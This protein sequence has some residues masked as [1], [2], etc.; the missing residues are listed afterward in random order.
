MQSSSKNRRPM[1]TGNGDNGLIA[2]LIDA[3]RQRSPYAVTKKAFIAGG[4]V[5][6]GLGAWNILTVYDAEQFVVYGMSS[7]ILFML[8]YA[9]THL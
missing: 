2:K 4:V 3:W 8:R 1:Q 9:L 7:M 6:A 5:F